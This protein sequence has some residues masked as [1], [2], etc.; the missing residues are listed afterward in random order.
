MEA[1]GLVKYLDGTKLRPLNPHVGKDEL[2]KP[3]TDSKKLAVKEYP[4]KLAEWRKE[5]GYAKQ[6]LGSSLPE[7]PL[8]KFPSDSTAHDIWEMLS[9]EFQNHSC[10]V[11]IELQQKLQD[12]WCADKGDLRVHFDK[13]ITLREELASLGHL[14][15]TDDFA[16][17]ILSSVPMSYESTLLAMTA[18]A[19]VSGQDLPPGIIMS[20]LLNSYNLR[21]A[22]LPKKST[23]GNN[24]TAYS[25]NSSKKFNG[26][27]NNCL[28]KGHKAERQVNNPRRSGSQKEREKKR[29]QLQM[30]QMENPM[31]FGLQTQPHQMTKMTGCER[32]TK[33]LPLS[34][35]KLLMKPKRPDLLIT[36][37][38]SL[39]KALEQA[40]A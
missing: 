33:K 36:V 17:M 22:K 21:Q 6:L 28:K 7:V 40:N 10:V 38:C 34:L 15:S 20:T 2:W 35:L 13:M 24:N 18:S 39:E 25:A 32:L 5:N 23:S 1:K 27:C 31:E 19:K 3:T 14:I 37:L 11:A 26:F 4:E 29:L 12:Q 9:D 30:L 8:I 16:S